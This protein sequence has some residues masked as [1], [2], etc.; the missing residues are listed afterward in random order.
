MANMADYIDNLTTIKRSK[1][2]SEMR[3]AIYENFDIL[4]NTKGI[5]KE[6]TRQQ[7]DALSVSEKKNGTMYFITDTGEIYKNDKQY[8]GGSGFNGGNFQSIV[9]SGSVALAIVGNA[10]IV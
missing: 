1:Y 5:S 3:N 9:L 10:T 7:Y 4:A 2:G 8:G 6:L